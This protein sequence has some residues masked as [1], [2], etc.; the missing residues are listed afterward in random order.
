MH[1]SAHSR[2]L[3]K[4]QKERRRTFYRRNHPQSHDAL[5]KN[6]MH[7]PR[8]STSEYVR[9]PCA[10]E[11]PPCELGVHGDGFTRL[12]PQ[13]LGG[14]LSSHLSATEKTARSRTT[15][16]HPHGLPYLSPRLHPCSRADCPIGATTYL[17]TSDLEP[18]ATH[19]FP[20]PRSNV[21]ALQHDFDDRA[22]VA[23]GNLF[24]RRTNKTFH[25]YHLN[26]QDS[27]RYAQIELTTELSRKRNLCC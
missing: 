2:A 14:T 25:P 5:L 13:G 22:I 11:H 17:S 19:I 18:L 15:P 26:L 3:Q 9:D 7:S 23:H 16:N 10:C 4:R 12:E 27:P 20:L 1:S 21:E 8:N 24:A 6:W